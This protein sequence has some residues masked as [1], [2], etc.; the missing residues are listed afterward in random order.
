MSFYWIKKKNQ[1][2]I[3]LIMS[4]LHFVH[5]GKDAKQA[6]YSLLS[7][8]LPPTCPWARHTTPSQLLQMKTGPVHGWCVCVYL[9][10][11]VFVSGYVC[12]CLWVCAS[13][14]GTCFLYST[15]VEEAECVSEEVTQSVPSHREETKSTQ[16]LISASII[17]FSSYLYLTFILPGRSPKN[18]LLLWR[19]A[20]Q[21]VGLAEKQ[22]KWWVEKEERV[23]I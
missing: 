17:L 13:T 21:Q 4:M 19:T 12:V 15:A 10:A 5:V 23:V 22:N 11:F 20:W 14:S 6:L 1:L 16:L 3:S 18:K 7:S 9:N 8:K 2:E